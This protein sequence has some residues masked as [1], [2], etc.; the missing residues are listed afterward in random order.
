MAMDRRPTEKQP[1][2]ET[3]SW[4]VSLHLAHTKRVSVTGNT[5]AGLPPGTLARLAMIAK[6]V[7]KSVERDHVIA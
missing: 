2:L 6:A 1:L 4:P 3:R 7:S 5:C